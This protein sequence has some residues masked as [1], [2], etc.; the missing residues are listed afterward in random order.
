MKG[1]TLYLD[2]NMKFHFGQSSIIIKL[3]II[4]LRQ[5]EYFLDIVLAWTLNN[6][7]CRV[8]IELFEKDDKVWLT[9]KICICSN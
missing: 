4:F 7:C 8:H 3:Q 6:F 1:Q 5:L 9:L 2:Y